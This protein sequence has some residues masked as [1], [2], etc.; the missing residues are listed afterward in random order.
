MCQDQVYEDYL[1]LRLIKKFFEIPGDCLC[2]Y[3][4]L[5]VECSSISETSTFYFMN[6]RIASFD[7]RRCILNCKPLSV[8]LTSDVHYSKDHLDDFGVCL[9]VIN[10]ILFI[11]ARDYLIK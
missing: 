7:K 2:S 11:G 10:D 5:R 4:D 9:E 3:D 6:T 1:R 8:R